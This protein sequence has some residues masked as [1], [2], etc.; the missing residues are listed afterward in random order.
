MSAAARR[1]GV[2]RVCGDTPREDLTMSVDFDEI[3]KLFPVTEN[4]A[5]FLAN[6]KSPLPRPVADAAKEMTDSIMN[7]GVVAMALS[8]PLINET[9]E[10][11]AKLLGCDSDEVAFSRNTTEGA[12]WLAQSMPWA[13]GDEVLLTR[14]EYAALV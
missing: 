9:R 12:L 7:S 3:R 4:F 1:Y 10:K 13:E 11:A 5:Y 6:G 8:R 14:H 2:F